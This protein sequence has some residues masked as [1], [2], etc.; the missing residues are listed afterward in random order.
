SFTETRGSQA[1]KAVVAPVV[2][3]T[4]ASLAWA[5]TLE[6]EHRKVVDKG[7]E[8]LAKVQH[9]DG[10]WDANAGQYTTSMTS[11][12]GMALLMEGSTL[13]EG[14]YSNNLRKAVDWLVD[15]SQKSG[16][17]GSASNYAEDG[18][19]MYGHGFAVLFLSSVYGEEEDGERRNR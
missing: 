4:L 15:R 13:R 16:L 3:L 6:P 17:I 8:Y 7:L 2:L 18:R 5:D 14:K 12:A 9:P 11:L 19:Y 1:M 10:H